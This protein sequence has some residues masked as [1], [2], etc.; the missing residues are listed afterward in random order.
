LTLSAALNAIAI[1]SILPLVALLKPGD[2]PADPI[3]ELIV[4]FYR[5]LGIPVNPPGLVALILGLILCR[6]LVQLFAML[7]I[8]YA[9]SA[10]GSDFRRRSLSAL[11]HAR[12]EHLVDQPVGYVQ[13]VLGREVRIAAD[14]VIAVCR[15]LAAAIQLLVYLV[16]ALFVSWAVT[17]CALI[18]GVAI[19]WLLAGLIT[20]I[21]RAS[22][23]VN[24]LERQFS[25]S[26]QEMFAAIKSFKAMCQ[27]AVGE[28]FLTHDVLKLQ[29][30]IRRQV[31]SRELRL[32]L[33][34]P[35][36]M[37]VALVGGLLIYARTSIET[38][39]VMLLVFERSVRRIVAIQR[40]YQAVAQA[41]HA[42]DSVQSLIATACQQLDAS[43]GRLAPPA[44]TSIS[45]D[46]V[47]FSYGENLV[48]R[49]ASLIVPARQL[50]LIT[51]PSGIGKSTVGDLVIGLIRPL[52]GSIKVDGIPLEDIE[53]RLWRGQIG[54]VPQD[55]PLFHDS[56]LT[57]VTLRDPTI[58]ETDARE[59]LRQAG[60]QG[61]IEGLPQGIATN[62]GERGARLSGGERQR[63]ALARALV[64]KPRLLILDEATNAL[65]HEAET[66][67]ARSLRS[68]SATLT[69]LAIAH[70][71]EL[72]NHANTI[73]SIEDGR[74]IAVKPA[75]S[76][77]GPPKG[78]FGGD[79]TRADS[80]VG[81]DA[82]SAEKFG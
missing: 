9:A 65:D 62:V 53:L 76:G 48:L 4:G 45:F 24:V 42:Y 72:V 81:S 37:C 30:A 11:L 17:V 7:Q 28:S 32:Q 23:D 77:S 13:S 16:A 67:L 73:Y 74:V 31:M 79:S 78:G 44:S 15:V 36:I 47:S 21:K 68:L 34:E 8:G 75:D 52:R 54:Y 25:K 51:G 33:E 1:V 19:S 49:D 66:A 29:R 12:W 50:T 57:N 46:S 20:S 69:I 5:D 14:S 18:A 63:I 59:A 40:D 10:I 22:H 55:A 80:D 41:E 38:A 6:S 39:V 61:F 3:A 26:I 71:S 70:R 58:S 56:I 2:G 60:A 35:I 82:R 27:E 64:R 43:D